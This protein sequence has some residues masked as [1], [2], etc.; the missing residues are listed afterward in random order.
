MNA[1]HRILSNIIR[2]DNGCWE[3]QGRTD[4]EGYPVFHY[5]KKH[6]YRTHRAAYVVLGN[7]VLL[8]D[9]IVHHKCHNKLCE[10]PDHLQQMT[11]TEHNLLEQEYQKECR[12][13]QK[14][15]LLHAV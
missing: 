10:N 12:A 3:W 11:V 5:K 15:L 6:R 9:H 14:E 4:R 8:P 7:N 13:K 2:K 1:A